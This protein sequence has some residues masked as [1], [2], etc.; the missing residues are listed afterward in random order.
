MATEYVFDTASD[1]GRDQ[2]D[3][4]ATLYDRISAEWL[5]RTG[6]SEGARCLEVGAG[7]GSIAR[8]LAA[9]VRP[10]GSV[11]AVDLD[12]DHLAA[13]PG[14]R[15]HRHDIDTGV[16][17]GAPFDLIHARLVLMHLSRRA[18]ILHTLADALAPGGWLVLGD[19]TDRLPRAISAPTDAD[20]A[21]FDRVVD[22]GTNVLAP[23][24]DM[25]VHWAGQT[26]ARM[27]D[28]GLADV[29]RRTIRTTA[30]GGT[31]GCLLFGNY[32]RQLE[33]MLLDVGLTAAELRRFHELTL[34]PRLH[35]EFYEL[36]Y[37]AGRKPASHERRVR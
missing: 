30:R 3:H 9:R 35:V 13:R 8:W 28:A 22:T 18:E 2:V 14:V 34:D 36:A 7:S 23:G 29:D 4:L 11:V 16:P 27:R 15:V 12:T 37:T 19:L 5:E 21:L 26:A 1:L 6:V 31:A 25:S 32:L 10:G 24:V 33:A 20:A 17:P